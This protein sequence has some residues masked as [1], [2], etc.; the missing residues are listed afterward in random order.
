MI[1]IYGDY[2]AGFST[3]KFVGGVYKKYISIANMIFLDGVVSIVMLRK[4]V[5]FFINV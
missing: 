3:N 1:Y 5:T 4:V 2:Y